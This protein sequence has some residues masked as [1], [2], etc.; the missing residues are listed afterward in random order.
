[1]CNLKY[2]Q[3]TKLHD[4]FFV[5]AIDFNFYESKFSISK[6][7]SDLITKKTHFE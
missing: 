7:H 3:M 6:L 2:L 4:R 5:Y 1:M